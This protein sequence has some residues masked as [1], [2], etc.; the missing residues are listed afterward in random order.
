MSDLPSGA[1][2]P[3]LFKPG[4]PLTANDLNEMQK[5]LLLLLYTHDHTGNEQSA[6]QGVPIGSEAIAPNAVKG[7]HISVNAVAKGDIHNGA[8]GASEIAEKCIASNHL[9]D[10]AVGTAQIKEKAVTIA[11][12]DDEVIALLKVPREGATTYVYAAY[13]DGAIAYPTHGGR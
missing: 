1:K 6:P 9:V 10:G 7:Q 3:V 11:K 8:V 5:A 13:L 4:Q 12:L 2:I